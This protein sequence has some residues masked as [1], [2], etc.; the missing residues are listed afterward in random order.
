MPRIRFE[1]RIEPCDVNEDG[2]DRV[3]FYISPNAGEALKPMA[4]IVS[5]GEAARVMLALKK[6]LEGDISEVAIS[7]DSEGNLDLGGFK[8][9]KKVL[10]NDAVRH[11]IAEIQ[12]KFENKSLILCT[13]LQ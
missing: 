9:P 4:M 2:H 8:T 11:D 6:A 1:C 10:T 7:D 5:S 13:T 12:T 3:S